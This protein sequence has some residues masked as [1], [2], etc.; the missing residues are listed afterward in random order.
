MLGCKAGKLDNVKE[1]YKTDKF[2][3]NVKKVSVKQME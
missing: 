3:A 2:A 1:E